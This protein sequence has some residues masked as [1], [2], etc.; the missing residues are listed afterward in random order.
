MTRL[1]VLSGIPRRD[2]LWVRVGRWWYHPVFGRV[3]VI[4]GG[5]NVFALTQRAYGWYE[6]G[7]ETTSVAIALEN[8]A[9]TRLVA[10]DSVVQLRISLEETGAGS[11]S[12]AT[13][14][15]FQLQYSKNGG[16]FTSITASSTNVKGFNSASLTDAGTTSNRL[17]VG[18]GSFVAGE[19]SEVGLVTDRQITA[20]N[21][22]EMLY[23][24]TLVAADLAEADQLTF[25][26]LLN[27]ATT[28][29]TFTVTPTITITKNVRTVKVTRA[30]PL[31]EA[32]G[33]NFRGAA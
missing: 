7:A 26:V 16:A 17:S 31:G 10:S 15:D 19:I 32:L 5:T 8:T 13:T 27:G 30:F 20:N 33:M 3:P 6:D 28:N 1:R 2:G 4:A 29:M 23:S 18:V 14:D 21:F 22:T 12:G 9:P 25:R 24:L 11:I